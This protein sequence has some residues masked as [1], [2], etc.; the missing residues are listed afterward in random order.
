VIET[1]HVLL[2]PQIVTAAEARQLSFQVE[3]VLHAQGN[4]HVVEP[5]EVD[6]MV[7]LEIVP[8]I[9]GEEPVIEFLPSDPAVEETPSETPQA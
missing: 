1:D 4:V 7:D 8:A 2:L 5:V 3:L 9:E 6:H